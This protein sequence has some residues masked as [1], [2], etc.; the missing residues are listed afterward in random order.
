[1]F[2][3]KIDDFP[4]LCREMSP[5]WNDDSWSEGRRVDRATDD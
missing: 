2:L 5:E 1:M 4:R 3:V